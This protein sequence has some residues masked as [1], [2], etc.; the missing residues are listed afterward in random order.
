MLTQPEIDALLSGV[1]ETEQQDDVHHLLTQDS[2]GEAEAT[3][4]EIRLYNFWSPERFSKDQMRAVELVHEDLAERLTSSL[5]SY[6]RTMFRPR[7]IH[8]EQGRYDDLAQGI[9]GNT[10]YNILAFDPLPGR[11]LLI[12]NPEVTWVILERLLGGSGRTPS[13]SRPLTDIGQALI[14]GAVEFMLNDVKA[15]WGKVANIEP[16]LEDATV[17]NLWVTMLMRNA[18]VVLI[19]FELLIQGVTGTMSIY[20]PL[21]MLKPIAAA[22]TPTAWMA[23]HE[24]KHVDEIAQRDLE[25]AIAETSVPLS[26]ELGSAKL[27]MAQLAQLSVG[28]VLLLGTSFQRDLLMSVGDKPRYK[29]T[30]GTHHSHL[31]VRITQILNSGAQR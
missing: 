25:D 27:T 11:A 29:V 20:I 19:T 24:E 6:L 22:L 17:N 10:L 21:T 14:R 28:D 26:V 4:K 2:S 15:S 16:R 12:F 3:E 7:L 23:G 30:P 18:R 5:P 13:A 1:I 31:A 8:I 9:P